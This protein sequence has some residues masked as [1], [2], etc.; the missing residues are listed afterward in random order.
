MKTIFSKDEESEYT[1]QNQERSLWKHVRKNTQEWVDI[2]SENDKDLQSYQQKLAIS[3]RSKD[4]NLLESTSSWKYLMEKELDDR[5][6][7]F[8]ISVLLVRLSVFSGTIRNP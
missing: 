3:S 8:A 7:T 1:T 4:I 6:L 5:T 2:C